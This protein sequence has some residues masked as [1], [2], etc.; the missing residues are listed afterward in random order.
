MS[1]RS[2]GFVRNKQNLVLWGTLIAIALL[3]YLYVAICGVGQRPVE[4]PAGAEDAEA[5]SRNKAAEERLINLLDK[6]TGPFKATKTEGEIAELE[7]GE[8]ETAQG[9]IEEGV[10]SSGDSDENGVQTVSNACAVCLEPFDEGERVV[11]S[12]K[13]K[14]CPHIFHEECLKEVITAS[15]SKGIY[16]VPCPCCRQTFVETGPTKVSS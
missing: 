11:S 9:D 14:G 6:T 15:T 5:Q 13:T 12:V 10:V 7:T 2:E 16:S 3:R 4:A 1:E 8:L